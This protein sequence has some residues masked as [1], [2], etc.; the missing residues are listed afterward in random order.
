MGEIK[1]A[2]SSVKY[3]NIVV[4]HLVWN[5]ISNRWRLA[6]HHPTIMNCSATGKTPVIIGWR[7]RFVLWNS[8][9]IWALGSSAVVCG[10]QIG[11]SNWE[12]WKPAERCG[13]STRGVVTFTGRREGSLCF[14]ADLIL[15]PLPTWCVIFLPQ[16]WMD[17]DLVHSFFLFIFFLQKKF[18]LFFCLADSKD[19][20]FSVFSFCGSSFRAG[21]ML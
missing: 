9:L 11:T 15:L 13:G 18:S 17:S 5:T 21:K 3:R 10:P 19:M 16:V 7:V 12:R 1:I 20:H 6:V 2:Q 4:V 14:F 8:P